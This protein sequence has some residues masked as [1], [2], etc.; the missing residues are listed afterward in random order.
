MRRKTIVAIGLVCLL[1]TVGL[2]IEEETSDGR[3]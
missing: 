2:A 1:G 3:I